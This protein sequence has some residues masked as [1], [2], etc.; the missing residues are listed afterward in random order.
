MACRAAEGRFNNPRPDLR[1]L[2]QDP[3]NG[4]ECVDV[5]GPDIAD[6]GFFGRLVNR[7]LIPFGVPSRPL[8]LISWSFFIA[9]QTSSRTFPGIFEEFVG[10]GDPYLPEPFDIPVIDKERTLVRV[11]AGDLSSSFLY[12]VFRSRLQSPV[13]SVSCRPC[14]FSM[15]SSHVFLMIRQSGRSGL[16]AGYRCLPP[17]TGGNP[18]HRDDR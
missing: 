5:I 14:S 3:F 9:S 12:W 18:F 2:P 7:I 15:V 11:F 17:R 6:K 13:L 4:E 16:P 1:C 10:K 8:I